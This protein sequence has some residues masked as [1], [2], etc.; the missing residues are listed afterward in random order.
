[1]FKILGESLR[2]DATLVHGAEI[3]I[4][5]QGFSKWIPGTLWVPLGGSKVTLTSL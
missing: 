4:I 2:A 3:H 1:M 5:T